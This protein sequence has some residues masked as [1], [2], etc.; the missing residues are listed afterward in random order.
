MIDFRARERHFVDHLAPLWHALGDVRGRFWIEEGRGL[1]LAYARN[2]GILDAE[3][4][5]KDLPVTATVAV[6][7]WG[8]LK[9]T[10]G[11]AVLLNHGSGQTYVNV[12][13]SGE[14]SYSGGPGRDR[15]I[16]FLEPNEYAAGASRATYPQAR[17]EVVGCPKLDELAMVPRPENPA[18]IVAF[19]WH[20]DCGQIAPEA[21]LAFAHFKKAI[22]TVSRR[23][24]TLGHAHPKLQSS[25]DAFYEHNG[26][27]V[28]RDFVDVVARADV[29]VCD[30][31]STLFEFAALDRP[32]V[33]LDAPWYRT[34][35]EH[36][37]RF[38]SHADVGVR[39]D[40]PRRLLW[41]VRQAI[42]D[43]P[44]VAAR[45]RELAADV[46]PHVGTATER[47]AAAIREVIGA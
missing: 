43:A 27:E 28:V 36:G 29:Y 33:V 9:R 3:P 8:D 14:A 38:W 35:V 4:A 37:L 2:A 44:D 7:S 31:S 21:T 13:D 47:A 12:R 16:L 26:I 42:E 5:P 15:V 34:N 11:P 32:V 22:P 19:S 41:A 17:T 39:I 24:R 45:R 20:F 10:H 6:A 30:N 1:T 25:L 18:P 46:F 40:N 23:F